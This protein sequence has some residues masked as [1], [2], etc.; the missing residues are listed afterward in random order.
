M[1]SGTIADIK[2][3]VLPTMPKVAIRVRE[4]VSNPDTSVPQLVKILST[5]P[6]MAAAILRVSN[7]AAFAVRGGVSSLQ[8]AIVIMGFRTLQSVVTAACAASLHNKA[9]VSFKDQ[10]L[11][12]HS[13][14]VALAGRSLAHECGYARED[15]AFLA[16][17]MHDVG[18]LVLDFN[19][20]EEYAKVVE[21]VYNEDVTFQ[22]AERELLGFDH[23]EIASLVATEWK[24]SPHLVEAVRRHHEPAEATIE[25]ALCA[26]VSLANSLCVKLCIGPERHP[27]LDLMQLETTS[28]LGLAPEKLEAI[29]AEL[30]A[31]LAKEKSLFGLK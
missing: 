5:D 15:E 10:V 30:P 21:R 29:A 4:M 7:S 24:L 25:P 2:V 23:T 8:Q 18:K 13:L 3:G 9:S 17:L 31:T 12:D 6:T 20:R 16:G 1:T 11:W 22:R 28:I 14:G 19:R 27:D 26:I